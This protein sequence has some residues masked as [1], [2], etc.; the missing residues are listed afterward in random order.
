MVPPNLG[1]VGMLVTTYHRLVADKQKKLT[2]CGSGGF[3]SKIGVLAWCGSWENP[4]PGCRLPTPHRVFTW[5]GGR[6]EVS[7]PVTLIRHQSHHWVPPS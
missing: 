2:S 3:K 1:L 6:Q 4:L 7:S 5:W